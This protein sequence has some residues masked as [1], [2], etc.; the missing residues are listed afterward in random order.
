MKLAV[1]F[2][3]AFLALCC[4]LASA[5]ICPAFLNVMKTLFVGTLS[6]YEAALEFFAPDADMRDGMIQLRNL[7][8]T[9]PSNTTQNILKFTGKVL[10]TPA[11]A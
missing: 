11:C 3:L 4:S 6:S 9:L 5:E 2:T 10:K 8:D 1:I 7:V